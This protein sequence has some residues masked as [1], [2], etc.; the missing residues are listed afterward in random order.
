MSLKKNVIGLATA[1]IVNYVLPLI[2]FPYL[3][4]VLSVDTFGIV[5][6]S[7][8]VVGAMQVITDYGLDLYMTKTITSIKEREKH[9]SFYL[10]Q[11]FVAKIPL[12]I[13]S[14]FIMLVVILKTDLRESIL[15]SSM[16]MISV[17]FNAFNPM[18][19]FQ[20]ME[21]SYIYARIATVFRILSLVLVFVVIQGD[22]DYVWYSVIM[23]INSI[24]LTVVSM[25]IAMSYSN[26]KS[27]GIDIIAIKSVLR[28][29]FWFFMSKSSSMIVGSA[30]VVYIGIVGTAQQ[31]AFYGVAEK[32]YTASVGAFMPM[33]NALVP[34]MTRTQNYTMIFKFLIFSLVVCLSIITGCSI[35]G[36]WFISSV[37]GDELSDS[38]IALNILMF[39]LTLNVVSM[40]FGYPSL[41][42]LRKEKYAN[43]S[44][45]IGGL[46]QI[47]LLAILYEINHEVNSEHVA[48]SV[49][50]SISI[51]MSIRICAFIKEYCNE[52]KRNE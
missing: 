37:F 22:S 16:L 7:I 43:A 12:L 42:P 44:T 34:Y 41:I 31:A 46:V 33:I 27:G 52:K 10:L 48:Y 15:Y 45:I 36:E 40:I 39:A 32:L 35:M 13:I 21:K 47:S 25:F 28:G 3:T 51:T 29:G 49:T 14:L 11:C 19:A 9:I 30:C 8:A 4:R 26:L 50:I 18:W 17:T 5:M 24:G 20:V 2:Q 38:I 23:S 6:I 1:Q